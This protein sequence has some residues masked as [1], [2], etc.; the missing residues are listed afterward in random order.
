MITETERKRIID[1]IHQEVVPAIGCTEPIAVALCVAKATETLGT[2]PEKINVLLSANILK[3]A[4]GVGIPGTGMIGLPIAIALG[5]LIGKS[6]YQLE[7]LKDSTPDVVEE[8]KRFIEEKRI[9]ILLKENIEEKLYIEV[10]CEAG[11]DK[12]TT[13]IAGGHTT[14]IYIERNGEVLFQKQH[15]ASCEKEEECLE[16]TLRKVYDFA[17]NTPLDEI[18]FILETARLNKAAAERSFE[19]NYGHGLGKMLRGTYEHKVMGDSVF[20]HILSYTSGACDARMA[21]AM[22]PVMS[23]SGSGNQGIS[24][25]LPVL[26]FAEEN[27]KSE[28]ELIR[29]LMLSHLTVIYIK[30][31]LGRLSALCGCVVAATGSSCG[32]TWLMGGTYDQVAYAVQN[33]IANLTGMICDGA[34]PSCALKVTTGVSTAVLSAIMAMENRCVTSVEG[35]IDEDVD[36]SIRNLTKIGSKGMNETDKLVLEIMT[37]K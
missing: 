34:K 3:N 14:F 18:S 9:H 35:I 27:D 10:C 37:G 32:I 23:N 2:K 36:Q 30:Q 4:M 20:S 12:A 13:V 17:L 19:G 33:M 26:V 5:A 15:T 31:S 29:A 22:I 8:G 11:D 6:E 21:G 16:L 7:V 24:A 28:E 1:L 25:T